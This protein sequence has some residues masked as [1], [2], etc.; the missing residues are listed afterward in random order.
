[1]KAVIYDFK[2][3]RSGAHTRRKFH[4]IYQANASPAAQQA[5][6]HIQRLYHY[7]T[8]ARNLSPP[9]RLAYRQRHMDPTPEQFERWLRGQ[10]EVVSPNSVIIKAIRYSLSN[11]VS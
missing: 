3:G 2:P 1:M 9:E 11:C 4:D 6:Q 10:F 8:E 7:E 5:L